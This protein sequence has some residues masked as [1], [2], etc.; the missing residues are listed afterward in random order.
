MNW[1]KY[2]TR[3]DEDTI[4][5]LQITLHFLEKYFKHETKEAEKLM[6]DFLDSEVPMDHEDFLHYRLPYTFAAVIHYQEHLK[7]EPSNAWDWVVENRYHDT[8]KEAM[9]YY[10]EKYFHS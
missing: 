10:Q 9:I 8:P 2:A 5:L 3:Y 7:G 6:N 4:V 1:T